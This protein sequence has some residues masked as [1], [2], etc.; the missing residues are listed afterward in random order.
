MRQDTQN[1]TLKGFTQTHHEV[2]T[3]QVVSKMKRRNM[4]SPPPS[5]I[6]KE[7][8]PSVHYSPP[9]SQ[10]FREKTSPPPLQEIN[11]IDENERNKMIS[12]SEDTLL[13]QDFKR[14]KLMIPELDKESDAPYYDEESTKVKLYPR[15]TI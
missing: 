6:Y 4:D 11:A 9:P 8:S 2:A 3:V 13:Q 5:Q 12:Y 15:L 14:F 7:R 1:N 10:V